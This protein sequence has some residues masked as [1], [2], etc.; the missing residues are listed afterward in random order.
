MITSRRSFL[1]GFGAAL[2]TAPAIVR[3]DSLMPVKQMPSVEDLND[4]L[5][6]RM[7]GAY[8]AMRENLDRNLYGDFTVQGIDEYGYSISEIVRFSKGH[9]AKFEGWSA[10]R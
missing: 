6:R 9:I 1:T 5:R 8:A 4:L 10:Y 7:D 3:A 2:I